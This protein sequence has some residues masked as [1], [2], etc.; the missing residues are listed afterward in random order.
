MEV[1]IMMNSGHYSRR[2]T[3]WVA[4]EI[5]VTVIGETEKA[6][7]IERYVE[8]KEKTYSTWLPKK[9]VTKGASGEKEYDETHWIMEKWFEKKLDGFDAWFFGI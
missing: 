6:Y 2:T 4:V 1:T 5:K 7:K 3:D 9:A 8:S